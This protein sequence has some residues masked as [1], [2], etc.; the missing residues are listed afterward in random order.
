MVARLVAEEGDLKGL[1]LSL[2]NGDSWIIGRDPEQCQLVIEDPLTS[3]KHLIARQTPEGIVFENLSTTNPIQ[4][5]DELVTDKPRLMQQGDTVRIGNEI[6]RFYSDTSAHIIEDENGTPYSAPTIIRNI[7]E[8]GY[9]T[10]I[11]EE[12]GDTIFDGDNEQTHLADIN[13]GLNETGRWLLK[14]ISGPNN[15]AEFYMQTGHSYTIGTDSHSC[16]IVFHD[17]SVSRQ[18]A[19]IAISDEDHLYIEDLK[20]R[21]GVLVNNEKIEGKLTLSPSVIVT[22]GTTS[23][24]V[25]DREGEMQTIISPL[26]PSIVKVL[27]H[28]E[29]MK[30]EREA[31]ELA[32]ASKREAEAASKPIEPVPVT[33]PPRN[34]GPIIVAS[35]IL[36]LF[37]LGSI[38]TY[39]L[40]KSEPVQ[41]ESLVEAPQMI[42]QVLTPYTSVKYSFNK[43]NGSLLLLGHVAS[44]ADKNQLM[45][46]LQNLKFIKNIDDSGLIIDEGVWRELNSVITRNPAWQGIT[47]HSPAAAE[48]VLSGYLKTKKQAEQLNDYIS[49]NFPYLDLLKNEIVVEEDLI[50]QINSWLQHANLANVTPQFSNGEVTLTGTTPIDKTDE[51]NDIVQKIKDIPGVRF[52]NNLTHTQTPESGIVNVTNQYEVT[53]QSR[54]GDKYTV[55]INGRIVSEGDVIDGMAI[56]KIS[57][58]AILLMKEG[59]TYRIDYNK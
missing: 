47:I 42:D 2:E 41:H 1:V 38:A 26:L 21:N 12:D 30:K 11:P 56:T 59:T 20:S 7:D 24:V 3:R 5:N 53:G 25:Y 49:I 44:G 8:N 46:G 52:V 23:F 37:S 4:V 32:A 33:P 16:D 9:L 58:N 48:F 10:K 35:I 22:M 29:E 36:G 13:F 28:D 55:I 34:W 54:V 45:Y 39:S 57:P 19:R 6:F 17:T 14:V 15:G 31:Q 50:S 43:A 27:Q 40:F 51:V 18:H